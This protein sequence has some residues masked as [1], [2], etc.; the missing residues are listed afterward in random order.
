M[1]RRANSE[2]YLK[3][4][5]E[6]SELFKKYPNAL[7]NTSNIANR[8]SSFD[9]TRNLNYSL[10]SSK[11]PNGYTQDEYLRHLCDEAAIRRYG[12][13]NTNVKARLDEE[14]RLIK[15]HNLAGFL[16]IYHEIIQ[17]ARDVMIDL[18]LTNREIPIE[19][20]PPGRG[21]G[22][23]VCMLVGYL[24][25]LSH[26]D[27]L[28]FDLSLERFLPD[29]EISNFPDIDLDFPRNIRTE[30]IKRIHK[31]YG[32]DR[33]ALT[34]MFSTYKAK[35]IIRDLGLALDIPSNILDK[36]A[37]LSDHNLI[38]D[39]KFAVKSYIDA[40]D[41]TG[42]QT[43]ENL[44]RLSI[45]MK[46]F[47]KYLA[48]H[49]GG[50]VVSSDTLIDLVPIQP[51]AIEERYIMQWDKQSISDAGFV[52]ID[53][54]ALGALSQLEDALAL[55]EKRTGKRLD[56]SRIDFD[57][58][59][60]Y[61]LICQSDTIGVF[62]VESA[63]Q[64]QT[65]P[66]LNPRNLFDMARQVASV[67]PGVGAN[68]G[69]SKYIR[70]RQGTEEIIYDHPL[71]YRA[72]ERTLGIIL[73]QDQVNQIAIDVAG[74]SPNDAD[75]LRRA[76]GK[77]NK[78]ELLTYYW[79]KFRYGSA[80]KDVPE[81]TARTIFSKFNGQYMFPESH[82]FAFGVTAYQTAWLKVYYPLEFYVSIFNQ[83]PMGFYNLETLKEDAM[84]HGIQVLHPHLNKSQEKCIIENTSI[85]L[86]F[87]NVKSIGKEVA[88]AIVLTR[89]ISGYF[90]SIEE[91]MEKTKLLRIPLDNLADAGVFDSLKQNRRSVRWEIGLRYH[92]ATI[93]SS[94]PL[95]I[96]QDMIDLNP[97]P[98]MELSIQEYQALGLNPSKHIMANVRDNLSSGITN[99][100]QL[101][102]IADGTEVT[103]AGLVIRRQRPKGKA[104]FLTLED[105]Y[106]HTSLII[107]PNIYK[108]Y[109]AILRNELLII[110]GEISRREGVVN[111]IVK[112]VQ[113]IDGPLFRSASKNWR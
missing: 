17:I 102:S 51:S 32:W 81:E 79:N 22:S 64:M 23:S 82:A 37:K 24:I 45:E 4:Q 108:K 91:F 12:D 57:D 11:V 112:S 85:R 54:L 10:P 9:L 113:P 93:Q 86:G 35:G 14:F 52:K 75:Q 8:C 66:R 110:K 72:L 103:M 2:F 80:Q 3:S 48:Q 44:L 100:E 58:Q 60:V 104:V 73:F 61:D 65:T 33:A 62:Q 107:W 50:M 63:A 69:V 49:P 89:D 105:E 88:N 26:I 46:G 96:S 109:Q 39:L 5:Q 40:E 29:D 25:G 6:M 1:E 18:K 97:A 7:E 68:D 90:N 16:L 56:L 15:K 70:R 76:Y 27:P 30:L 98:D 71:E 95:P 77:N 87:L 78:A 43:W 101:I 74:F 106:G 41:S 21:R 38:D 42:S 92:A 31:R 83:Q 55:I 13:N 47:P 67:R 19:E 111:V 59:R 28:H 99:S 34:G 84:R 94:L 53:F 36:L 20:S